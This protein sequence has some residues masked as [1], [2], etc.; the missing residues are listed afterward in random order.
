[1]SRRRGIRKPLRE[2]NI[3]ARLLREDRV[4]AMLDKA[5][6]QVDSMGD[7]DLRRLQNVLRE[8]FREEVGA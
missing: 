4:F 2:R 3:D 5:K 7:G 8:Y 1:V 6:S